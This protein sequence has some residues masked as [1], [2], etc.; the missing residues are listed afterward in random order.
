MPAIDELTSSHHEDAEGRQRRSRPFADDELDQQVTGCGGSACCN[1]SSGCHRFIALILMC[2]IGFGEFLLQS[3]E[4]CGN[5]IITL[6]S[7]G[8]YF[9][10]DNP[11]ALQN[12][13][14]N[15]MRLTTSQFVWLYSIY[16]WPNVILC[17]IGGFLLDR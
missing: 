16:S 14:K 3:N 1:P 2:L 11:G 13:M 5:A 7:I 17:F 4:C 12:D 8:S 6:V 10:Y 15:D 9:C